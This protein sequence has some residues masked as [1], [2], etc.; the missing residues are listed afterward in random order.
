MTTD[1]SMQFDDILKDDCGGMREIPFA[2]GY[3]INAK[4]FLPATGISG[5]NTQHRNNHKEKILE[6]PSDKTSKSKRSFNF[7]HCG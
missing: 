7:F 6:T 2:P 3:L 4:G 1:A 5:A